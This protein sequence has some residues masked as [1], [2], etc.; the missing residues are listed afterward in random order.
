MSKRTDAGQGWELVAPSFYTGA[1]S[2][3]A[4]N[5]HKEPGH[6]DYGR[7]RL[8]DNSWMCV[9]VSVDRESFGKGMA[10]VVPFVNG[11]SDGPGTSMRMEGT[12]SNDVPI[13]VGNHRNE[14]G[15]PVEGRRDFSIEGA[16]RFEQHFQGDIHK[17]MVWKQALNHKQ[18]RMMCRQNL[19]KMGVKTG[20]CPKGYEEF[21]CQC[22]KVI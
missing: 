14:A 18:I 12:L 3:Y 20:K 1:V 7:S 6:I 21:D 19:A 4:G 10:H 5:E 8:P 11:F 17:V 13:T 9:G 15:E 2:L 22:Y 16:P